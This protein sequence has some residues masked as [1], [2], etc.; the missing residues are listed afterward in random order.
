MHWPTSRQS[1][2]AKP[3][4]ITLSS[5]LHCFGNCLC[6]RPSD[7]VYLAGYVNNVEHACQGINRNLPLFLEF[8]VP[9]S[10][11]NCNGIRRPFVFFRSS[12]ARDCP[13]SMWR[14]SPPRKTGMIASS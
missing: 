8:L 7:R 9:K 13:W 11:R 14:T 5:S 12:L 3:I 6:L 2:F 10:A 1:T 4:L